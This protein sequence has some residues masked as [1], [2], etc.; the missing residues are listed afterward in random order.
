[1]KLKLIKII[2]L[3]LK[4]L[5]MIIKSATELPVK[6]KISDKSISEGKFLFTFFLIFS[7][8]LPIIFFYAIAITPKTISNS[9]SNF[10]YFSCN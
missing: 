9:S 5:I 3:F 10:C 1:M 4:Y 7:V 6:L 8:V 2:K